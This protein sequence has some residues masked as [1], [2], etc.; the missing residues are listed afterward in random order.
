MGSVLTELLRAKYGVAAENTLDIDDFLSTGDRK[1]VAPIASP[2]LTLLPRDLHSDDSFAWCDLL[3][4]ALATLNKSTLWKL[5]WQLA[6]CMGFTLTSHLHATYDAA[7]KTWIWD[8]DVSIT[9]LLDSRPP[10]GNF[11]V[12]RDII[13]SLVL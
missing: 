6:S 2:A 4:L 7:V 5:S 3:M 8:V 9:T 12:E 1:R 11:A 10:A 13:A